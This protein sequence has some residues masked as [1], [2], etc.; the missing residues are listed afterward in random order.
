MDC[1]VLVLGA[2]SAGDAGSGRWLGIRSHFDV[3]AGTELLNTRFLLYFGPL[4]LAR[5]N[6]HALTNDRRIWPK[7][8]GC[9]AL[10]AVLVARA[11][12]HRRLAA[13]V[14]KE[15]GGQR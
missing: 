1:G 3:A 2:P 10:P 13:E 5:A 11:D 8:S 4:S 14:E 7:S 9:T 12:G 6:P 15:L